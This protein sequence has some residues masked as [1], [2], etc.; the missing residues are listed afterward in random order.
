ML[1]ITHRYVVVRV[2]LARIFEL[3]AD[4]SMYYWHRLAAPCAF[5][6]HAPSQPC[7]AKILTGSPLL[8]GKPPG[9]TTVRFLNAYIRSLRQTRTAKQMRE[10]FV[11]KYKKK[12]IYMYI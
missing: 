11:L 9:L 2:M 7:S 8:T 4:D 6:L 1:N 12:S 3:N 10:I 5:L